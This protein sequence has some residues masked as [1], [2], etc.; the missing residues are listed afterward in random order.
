MKEIIVYTIFIITILFLI[1]RIIYKTI[2]IRRKQKLK[3]LSNFQAE[4]I[5]LLSKKEDGEKLYKD[6]NKTLKKSRENYLNYSLVKKIKSKYKKMENYINVLN[7]DNNKELL[8]LYKTLG[9]NRNIYN[10]EYIEKELIEQEKYFDDMYDYKLDEEQRKAIITDEDN[11]LIIASAGSGKTS[12]IVAK[13]K[14]LIEKKKI[15]PGEIMV[16]SFTNNAV[17]N[18]KK[19]IDND[20]ISVHTF[21]KLASNILSAHKI[22]FKIDNDLIYN[23]VHKYISEDILQNPEELKKL[24]E[25]LFIYIHIP[26]SEEE[27]SLGEKIEYERGFHTSILKT[28]ATNITF[29]KKLETDTDELKKYVNKIT[30]EDPEIKEILKPYLKDEKLLLEEIKR[31]FKYNL[32]TLNSERVK[33]QEELIIA[34]YLFLHGIKYEYEKEYIRKIKS[35]NEYERK[36]YPDFYLTD[37]DIYLEH[38]GINQKGK[39]PQYSRIEEEIYLDGINWKRNIHKENNTT[40][41]ETYSFQFNNGTIIEELEKLLKKHNVEIKEMN[42]AKLFNDIIR[43]MYLNELTELEGLIIKFIK[44]FKSNKY[45]YE[46]FDIFIEDS[47][48]KKDVRDEYLLNIFKKVYKKYIEQQRYNGTIDLEDLLIEANKVVIQKGI[49]E[50]YK[51]IIIDEYQDIALTRYDLVKSIQDLTNCKVVAVGDDWQSIFRFSGCDLEMFI[52]FDK[53]FKHNEKMY[54]NNTYRNSQE[55]IDIASKFIMKN[56][57]GQIQKNPKSVKNLT[58]PMSIYY[59]DKNILLATENAI[60]D[61]I[62]KGCKNIAILGRNN[63]DLKYYISDYN[64]NKIVPYDLSKKF[65]HEKV[66]FI[67]VHKSKGLE[68]DG[69]IICN[70]VNT[71]NGFP[72]KMADDPVLNY[73]TISEDDYLYE[74]ERRLF[75]VAL[76]RTKSYC[77]VLAPF[78]RT[79]IFV[80][81]IYSENKNMI[82]VINVEE[83]SKKDNPICPKCKTGKLVVRVNSK[84]KTE[85]ISCTNYPKCN[86]RSKYI[87]IVKN[88]I[89]CDRCG[90]FLVKKDGKYGKFYGCNKWPYCTRTMD[91]KEE[92]K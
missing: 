47:I 36:Y 64:P 44:L 84:E 29:I 61:L 82:E 91:I 66:T 52:N 4:L 9:K 5:N 32:M 62:K 26:Y 13:T 28:L 19:Q 49:K 34:N 50:K 16:I 51:Y 45:E 39:T 85:F 87:D 80:S 8:K 22:P 65:K 31:L 25:L 86:Y 27:K 63:S 24:L 6:F 40:L 46:M 3:M 60:K 42:Y 69:V 37:Y 70:G 11:N 38:F 10:N 14:Y 76:T 59:Y 81:E 1:I 89:K 77:S 35:D 74:E 73:V 71:I 21:H 2:Q 58:K 15:N 54:I 72:N 18:F 88:P 55:L 79:S 7:Y 75:Y 56:E 43:Y 33:S 48:N 78:G 92:E 90:D 41:L 12:T 67:T 23:V 30:S 68:Y 17:N 57:K 83:D 53:Y 20:A